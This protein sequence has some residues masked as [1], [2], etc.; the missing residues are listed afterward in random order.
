MFKLLCALYSFGSYTASAVALDARKDCCAMLVLVCA[1]VCRDFDSI[2]TAEDI[3]SG[4][5]GAYNKNIAATLS[6]W[7]SI[8]SPTHSAKS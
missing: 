5:S 2:A 8:S 6:R 7:R 1:A 4:S 3:A